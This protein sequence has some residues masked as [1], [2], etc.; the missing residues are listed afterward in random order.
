MTSHIETGIVD[1]LTLTVSDVNRSF[2]FYS[3]VLGFNKVAE[4]GPRIITHNGSFLMALATSEGNHKFDETRPG[5]DHLW[6][7]S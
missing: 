3:E 4:F 5:L 2:E 6:F 1:H 7:P